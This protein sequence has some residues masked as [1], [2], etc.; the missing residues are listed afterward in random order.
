MHDPRAG[1]FFAVDPLAREYA[2]LTPYQFASNSP[3]SLVEAEGCEGSYND[4]GFK[5]LG[6]S[7]DQIWNNLVDGSGSILSTI[8]EY[9]VTD[10]V[11]G[12][13]IYRILMTSN[14]YRDVVVPDEVSFEDLG[15]NFKIRKED[16][17]WVVL[18][19]EGVLGDLKDLTI[20]SLDVAAVFPSKG[21]GAYMA[22]K[23]GFASNATVSSVLKSIMV[24]TRSKEI[25]KEF[26]DIGGSGVFR[27]IETEGMA[28][29]EQTFNT[30]VRAIKNT[31]RKAGDFIV[32]TGKFSRKSVDLVSAVD[33]KGFSIDKFVKSINSHYLKD[34]VDIINIDIRKLGSE[35]RDIVKKNVSERS[36]SDQARTIITE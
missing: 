36:A 32:T 18:P 34:G 8:G 7:P 31:D 1:R 12:R 2:Y 29:F 20:S 5:D 25:L 6:I 28:I 35:A 30:T 24:S 21:G 14:I 15:S 3:I 22:I 27:Q 17:N 26:K 4:M 10:E 13:V 11:E 16:R 23:T 19:E 33:N 9:G